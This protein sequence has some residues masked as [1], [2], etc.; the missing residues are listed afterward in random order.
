MAARSRLR[1]NKKKY[2]HL[3]ERRKRGK[4]AKNEKRQNSPLSQL[5]SLSLHLLRSKSP[6]KHPKEVIGQRNK[7]KRRKKK[8]NKKNPSMFT[9]SE[10]ESL[11]ERN[12]RWLRCASLFPHPLPTKARSG[13]F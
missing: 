10:S 2:G 1:E 7:K 4:I 13:E 8:K 9:S 12:P 5:A 6:Q 11:A 3:D